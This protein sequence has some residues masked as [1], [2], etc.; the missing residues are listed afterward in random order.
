M[1]DSIE[2]EEVDYRNDRKIPRGEA[3]RRYAKAC[4]TAAKNAYIEWKEVYNK[5]GKHIYQLW[6]RGLMKYHIARNDFRYNV[7]V[8]PDS[9]WLQT[10]FKKEQRVAIIFKFKNGKM[11]VYRAGSGKGIVSLGYPALSN[12]LRK[13]FEGAGKVTKGA[14]EL[15][16]G[17][18][19]KL[20]QDVAERIAEVAERGGAKYDKT[21]SIP[22]NYLRLNRPVFAS[23]CKQRS[24]G[25]NEWW[26]T[27]LFKDTEKKS[28]K[29]IT[30]YDSR[31][32]TKLFYTRVLND[33]FHFFARCSISHLIRGFMK[34]DHMQKFWGA[35][36]VMYRYGETN[37]VL[38]KTYREILKRMRPA[39]VLDYFTDENSTLADLRDSARMIIQ[40]Q[41]YVWPE[42]IRNLRELHDSL[43]PPRRARE[44]GLPVGYLGEDFELEC[45]KQV[46]LVNG[47]KFGDYEIVAPK[48]SHQMQDWGNAMNNCIGSYASLVKQG[49]TIIL[50]VLEKGVIKYGIE[51]NDFTIVQFRGKYNKEP[52]AAER[53]LIFDEM[54]KIIPIE[55]EEVYAD[56]YEFAIEA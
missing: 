32:I 30:G 42:R 33:K 19:I 36:K 37:K 39:A 21:V 49:Q 8:R 34:L 52:E 26:A 24:E 29:Y 6:T 2:F 9:V 4:Q 1:S 13:F 14:A 20:Q 27:K 12:E 55:N 17:L 40:R 31:L 43:L 16:S 46:E 48:S 10:C 56:D 54:R 18:K 44:L 22:E 25:S 38:I 45:P 5:D 50:G 47:L 3:K 23:I 53:K 51:L 28:I 15:F 11:R 7:H 41:D 35:E